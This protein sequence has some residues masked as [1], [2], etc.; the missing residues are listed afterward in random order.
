VKYRGLYVMLVALL[1][2]SGCGQAPSEPADP[3]VDGASVVE[4]IEPIAEVRHDV[5]YAC[6]CG[7][8]CDCGSVATGPGSCDCGTELAA[9]HL[10]KVEGN[11]G[12]LCACASGCS[13]ELDS[14]DSTKCSCGEAVRRVSFE[15][16]GVYYC[17]C[18]GSCTCQYADSEPGKCACGMELVTS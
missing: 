9:F 15:G 18:G 7:P 11:T 10:L 16:K 14:E 12:L 8:D 1:V 2:I 4:P 13:C 3:V 5:V 17:N 6:A